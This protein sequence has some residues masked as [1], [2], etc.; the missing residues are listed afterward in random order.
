MQKK[1]LNRLVLYAKYVVSE[2]LHSWQK[3]T[4]SFTTFTIKDGFDSKTKKVL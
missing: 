4:S 1:M 3:H 2:N